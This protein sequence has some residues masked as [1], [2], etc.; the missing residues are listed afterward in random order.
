MAFLGSPLDHR[1]LCNLC[2]NK[3]PRSLALFPQIGCQLL[4]GANFAGSIS[5]VPKFHG[6]LELCCL[7]EEHSSMAQ[8]L[9]VF[10]SPQAS[11]A[12]SSWAQALAVFS[13]A[14]S[15]YFSCVTIFY[16]VTRS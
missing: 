7:Q 3:A 1:E 10:S 6:Q 14:M 2:T 16:S 15:L 11:A 9:G 13:I 4:C 8:A 5:V 12:F